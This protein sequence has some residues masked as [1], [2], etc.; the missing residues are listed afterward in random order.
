[1]PRAYP[2]APRIP[3]PTPNPARL[4]VEHRTLIVVGG[5]AR[6]LRTTDGGRH[7]HTRTKAVIAI[8]SAAL[9]LG[10]GGVA[11]AQGTGATTAGHGHRAH[12]GRP[13]AGAGFGARPGAVEHGQFVTKDPKTGAQV[14]HD[15]AGGTVT[16]VS[17]TSIAVKTGDGTTVTFTVAPTTRVHV[18]GQARKTT[19][20][21]S[22]IRTGQQ[23]VVL[24]TGTGPFTA[25]A[26]RAR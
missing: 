8:G 25:T 21:I 3:E 19:S 12:P 5:G 6:A 20:T 9:V 15:I 26:V 11:V 23:V 14:T 22:A 16:A 7:L 4:P 17:A 10:T 1:M 18:K 13:G 2:V 24:G